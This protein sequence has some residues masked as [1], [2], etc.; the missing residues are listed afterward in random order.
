M[1]ELHGDSSNGRMRGFEPRYEGSSPP[2]PIVRSMGRYFST[3][4][5]PNQGTAD[6]VIGFID[7][8]NVY[9]D[10]AMYSLTYDPITDALI[11]AHERGVKI[12]VLMDKSQ[13]GNKYAD[14]EKLETAGIQ[15]LRDRK[16]G[17][18]HHKF[19]IG[20]GTAVGL[21]SFNWTKNAETSNSENW[22][23]VRLKYAIEEY[24][25]EFNRLWELNQPTE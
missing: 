2:S 22:N 4:F 8:C 7:R 12:R 1:C 9:L 25:V 21:G 23:V 17:L 11:R 6:V 5:S 10:I 16:S 18:M 3:Y 24:Q 19:A 13:A 14:D 20:D 15:V